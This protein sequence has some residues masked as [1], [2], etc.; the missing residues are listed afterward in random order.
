MVSRLRG[1]DD[2]CAG[3][4]IIAA[5]TVLGKLFRNCPIGMTLASDASFDKLL[6]RPSH[7]DHNLIDGTYPAGV[8]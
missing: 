1:N 6:H 3:M 5:P 2:N 8:S 4:T 7:C